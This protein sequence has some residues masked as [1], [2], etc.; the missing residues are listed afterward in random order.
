M[1]VISIHMRRKVIC[2]SP[3]MAPSNIPGNSS[4]PGRVSL[5]RREEEMTVRHSMMAAVLC[6]SSVGLV[7]AK[8][9]RVILSEPALAGSIQLPAG[10]YDVKLEGNNAVMK[11]VDNDKT[12]T[13]PVKVE[14]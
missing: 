8:S 9:H 6:L 11:N 10:S 1:T 14:S 12:F 4:L 13:A 3:A 5:S 2:F 7:H